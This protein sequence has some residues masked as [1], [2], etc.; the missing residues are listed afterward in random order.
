MESATSI[1]LYLTDPGFLCRHAFVARVVR[2]RSYQDGLLGLVLY[3]GFVSTLVE[4]SDRTNLNE[5]S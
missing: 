4:S 3:P 5:S 1:A 2:L